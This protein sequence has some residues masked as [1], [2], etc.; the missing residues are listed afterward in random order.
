MFILKQFINAIYDNSVSLGS[1]CK[2]CQKQSVIT[3]DFC[4]Y[5][6]KNKFHLKKNRFSVK[7][8]K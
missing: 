6:S 8:N 2:I 4:P 3:Y 5:P 7:I 1:I